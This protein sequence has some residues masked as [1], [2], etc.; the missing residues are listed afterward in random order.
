M[1]SDGLLSQYAGL[2]NPFAVPLAKTRKDILTSENPADSLVGQREEL[3]SI[4]L[5]P[6]NWNQK[7]IFYSQASQGYKSRHF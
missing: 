6:W 7:V 1:D 2:F 3:K 4:L 5:L